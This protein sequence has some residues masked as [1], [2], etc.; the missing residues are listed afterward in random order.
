[1]EIILEILKYTIPAIIVF[2]GVYFILNKFMEGERSKMEMTYRTGN[3]KMITPVK[4]QAYERMILFLE[5]ISLSNLVMRTYNGKMSAKEL[6]NALLTTIRSEYDHN[7]S[8]Q[9]YI[10][11]KTWGLIKSSREENVKVINSCAEQLKSD[12]SGL[13]LSQFLLEVVGKTEKMPTDVAIEALKNEV[14]RTF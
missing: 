2:V 8:Q 1:M 12:A 3:S 13:E 6:Q 10:P 9:L 7:V 4:L 5:R 14:N 11:T